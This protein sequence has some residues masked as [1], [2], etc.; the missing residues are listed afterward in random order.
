MIDEAVDLLEDEIDEDLRARALHRIGQHRQRY[1]G[2]SK[3]IN[4]SKSRGT[5]A[6]LQMRSFVRLI[7]FLK[8]PLRMDINLIVFRPYPVLLHV[9][10]VGVQSGGDPPLALDEVKFE[11]LGY[12]PVERTERRPQRNDRRAVFALI[13]STRPDEAVDVDNPVEA[14]A[15]TTIWNHAGKYAPRISSL[16]AVWAAKSQLAAV[17]LSDKKLGLLDGCDEHTPRGYSSHSRL[18]TIR[19]TF[20]GRAQPR[21]VKKNA[22]P[23]QRH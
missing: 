22:T 11:R 10:D 5:L 8:G 7:S 1:T 20:F 6:S 12:L 18:S 15:L 19:P 21:C 14:L 23:C 3:R 16:A 4:E 9:L 13:I 2:P 17:S